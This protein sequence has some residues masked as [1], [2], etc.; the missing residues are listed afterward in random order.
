[1]F[2]RSRK[3]LPALRALALLLVCFQVLASSRG[4]VPSICLTLRDGGTAT[5]A[6][7]ESSCCTV[8]T[9]ASC[10]EPKPGQSHKPAGKESPHCAFCFLAKAYTEA[11]DFFQYPHWQELADAPYVR[12]PGAHHERPADDRTLGRAPPFH[13]A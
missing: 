2:S 8:E 9:P 6:E 5:A 7:Q 13:K 11:P 1:M 10:C 3:M 4:L 12:G